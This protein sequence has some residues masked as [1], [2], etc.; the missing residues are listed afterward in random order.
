MQIFSKFDRRSAATLS[1][2]LLVGLVSLDARAQNIVYHSPN[3]DG[4]NPGSTGELL[5][6][7]GESLF[8][9]L[10]TGSAISQVGIVCYDGDGRET[11]GYEAVIDAIWMVLCE[12]FKTSEARS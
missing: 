10:D 1:L 7:P 8:L 12:T 3:D 4:V 5:I 11:C 6:G 9:Y 2:V